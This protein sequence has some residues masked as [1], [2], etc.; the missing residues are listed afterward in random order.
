MFRWGGRGRGSRYMLTR[1]RSWAGRAVRN[2]LIWDWSDFP[3]RDIQAKRQRLRRRSGCL[4]SRRLRDRHSSHHGQPV[5]FP[6]QPSDRIRKPR[7]PTRRTQLTRTATDTYLA[8]S[9][10]GSALRDVGAVYID[11]QIQG[12]WRMRQ[13][14]C[15]MRQPIHT[16]AMP[17]VHFSKS[18]LEDSAQTHISSS[19]VWGSKCKVKSRSGHFA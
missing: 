13:I 18:E 9:G 7:T 11:G 10:A 15:M 12:S 16:N 3:L 1:A 8:R 6:N 14:W 2:M 5:S 17:T 4:A 19:R